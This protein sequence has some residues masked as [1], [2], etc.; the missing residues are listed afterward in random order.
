MLADAFQTGLTRRMPITNGTGARQ[1]GGAIIAPSRGEAAVDGEWSL[2]EACDRFIAAHVNGAWTAKT[3][4]R[5]R[6]GLGMFKQFPGAG[7]PLS[8]LD[9]GVVGDYKALT[10]SL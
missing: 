4:T 5:N 9:R 3:E 8:E 2:E 6:A 10:E 7:P 1:D